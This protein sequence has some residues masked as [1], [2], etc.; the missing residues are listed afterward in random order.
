MVMEKHSPPQLEYRYDGTFNGFLTL[1]FDAF[2]RKEQPAAIVRP[3]MQSLLFAN[4]YDV[5]TSD[6]KSERV[7]NGIVK[8]GGSATGEHLYYAFLSRNEGAEMSMLRY[9][10]HLFASKRPVMS[11]LAH[12]DVLAVH[13]LFKKVDRECHRVLMFLRFEQAADGTYFAPYAPKY[14]VIPMT[15]AHFKSRFADQNWLIYDTLRQ[16]GIYYNA[17]EGR[18]ERI[19]LDHAAFNPVNGELHA[20]TTHPGDDNWQ[21][22]WQAYFKSIAIAERKNLRQQQNFMPKRFWKYLTEKRI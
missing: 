19:T 22:L 20:D 8:T 12:P 7:W 21:S 3:G 10:Q 1:V 9:C 14:D 16:Y 5:V 4:V 17:A 15:V 11:D 6:P 13:Q 18:A 2:D